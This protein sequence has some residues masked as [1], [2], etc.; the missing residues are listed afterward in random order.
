MGGTCG[1]SARV[2]ALRPPENEAGS[3]WVMYTEEG[4]DAVYY[5]NFRTGDYTYDERVCDWHLVLRDGVS[6]WQNARSGE[7][8]WDP[9]SA[10]TPMEPSMDA[11]LRYVSTMS[12]SPVV[13][14]TDLPVATVVA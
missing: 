1:R 10:P 12:R 2:Q 11:I 9:P 8:R 5:Y 14:A 13:H 6:W 4:T 7:S 3:P